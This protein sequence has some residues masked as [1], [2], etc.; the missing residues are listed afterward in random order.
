MRI[1]E[2]AWRLCESTLYTFRAL[3]LG[4]A[5]SVGYVPG[6]AVVM[7]GSFMMTLQNA[8][9]PSQLRLCNTR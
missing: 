2:E 8:R 5:P 9:R 4:P 3:F 1:M 6:M 7:R